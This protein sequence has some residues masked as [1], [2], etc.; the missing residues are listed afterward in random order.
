M[1]SVRMLIK[2]SKLRQII[3]SVIRE[4]MSGNRRRLKENDSDEYLPDGGHVMRGVPEVPEYNLA[5]PRANAEGMR[6]WYETNSMPPKIGDELM[7]QKFGGYGHNYDQTGSFEFTPEGWQF[8]EI[9][10]EG[11]YG[12][13]NDEID[14]WNAEDREYQRLPKQYPGQWFDENSF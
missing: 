14:A 6:L 12:P 4:S 10:P 3:K 2:E 7:G 8:M 13:S 11:D 5:D 1:R 9:E